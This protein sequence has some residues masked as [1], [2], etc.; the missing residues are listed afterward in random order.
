MDTITAVLIFLAL[1]IAGVLLFAPRPRLDPTPPKTRVPVDLT[2]AQ[3][4]DWL[5]AY[6]AQHGGV[7]E[8]A[9]ATIEWAD[10]PGQTDI[11]LL[12]NHGFS[13]S[14]QEIVPV[15]ARVAK[16]FGANVV[17]TRMAGHGLEENGMQASAEDWLQSMVDGWEIASRLG[18]RVVIMA[19]SNGAPLSIWL[20]QQVIQEG[21]IHSFIF[22]SPNFR[23]RNP[24]G[25]L[26][27]WPGSRYWGPWLI[28]KEQSWEPDNDMAAKYWTY[29]Y[30]TLAVIEM[31]KVVDWV[32]RTSL[33]SHD[34]PLATF[35]M[36]DDP[37]ISHEAAVRFHNRWQAST[38]QLHQVDIDAENPQH[39]FVGN[40]SAPQRV[41]WC[42]D[43][44]ISFLIQ[45]DK[46]YAA[47]NEHDQ[48]PD[49]DPQR[50]TP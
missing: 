23:I 29:R 40:I 41:D 20:S 8:G 10:G 27:T 18:K 43:A 47:G 16:H 37:T 5:N 4:D 11:C 13:A 45:A 3:L 39:V 9:E 46:R 14:R 17:Y 22:L 21:Q 44:C 49:D 6:E 31:Q 38:K 30:S 36:V 28:G 19:T 25:F 12:Y 35:Y 33:R 48:Q 50:H 42:V 26:L 2:P 24:M 7:I 32:S 1:I 34:I 15:P